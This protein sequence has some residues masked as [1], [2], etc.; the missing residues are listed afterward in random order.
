[1]A[2]SP[3][4]EVAAALA[5]V[6]REEWGR[7]LAATARV[8][9]DL[10]LAEEC[11]QDAFERA[12]ERWPR[13][14][15][16][17][18]PGA[19]L[20]T[21]AGNRARDVVRREVHGRRL[22]PMLVVEEDDPTPYAAPQPV[23]DDRLRLVFTCCHPSL[24]P[25]AQV[26][27]TLRFV[28]GLSTAD[29]ARAF[30]VQE[31][32]MAARL[33]RAKKKIAAARIPYR[34]PGAD[35]LP[36]RLGPVLDVVH[37]VYTTGHAAPTG[38]VLVRADLVEVAVS[39]GR[40]LHQLLPHE[41]AVTG[42][43][44]LML[45]GQARRGTRVGPAGE[46]VLLAEQ[47]RSR[48]DRDLIEEAESLVAE[49]L[50]GGPPDRFTVEAAIAAVHAEAPSWEQTDWREIAGL[51]DVLERLWPTSVVRLNR[52]VAIGFRDG[53]AAGLAALAPLLDETGS[54]R[55]SLCQ[56]R[57][58]RPPAPP[59]GLGRGRRRLRGGDHP[60]RQRGGAQLPAGTPRRDAGP[61]PG[62][63]RPGG[64]RPRAHLLPPACVGA[65]A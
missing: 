41:T 48:W 17:R 31:S 28:C 27:L 10:D 42:L 9:R 2:T 23:P 63:S 33:T 20:T 22:L 52:A 59:R 11:T 54:G 8:T 6:H 14:G 56:R 61:R 13:D 53:P 19:W 40:M 12:L 38:E 26:A 46:L 64:I 3:P 55:L 47:D 62:V 1:M 36:T 58:C 43:L 51:Y 39:M 21:V 65:G 50:S 5:L 30:L 18:R 60:D 35:E 34:A 29:V 24:A 4:S 25:E 57:P 16:P 44:A 49:A 37:L 15:I 32:T 7:V 45:L